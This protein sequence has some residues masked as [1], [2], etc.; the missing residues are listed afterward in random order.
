MRQVLQSFPRDLA[1]QESNCDAD[2]SGDHL[3]RS[4]RVLKKSL[5]SGSVSMICLAYLE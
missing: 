5:R 4:S 2:D 3:V 1:H